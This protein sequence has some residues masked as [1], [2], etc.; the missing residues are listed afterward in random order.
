MVSADH[1]AKVFE[2]VTRKCY[3][4]NTILQLST[5]LHRALDLIF[6]TPKIYMSGIA[7]VSIPAGPIY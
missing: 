3:A 2:Q 6:A 4:M 7:M 5:P 1:T